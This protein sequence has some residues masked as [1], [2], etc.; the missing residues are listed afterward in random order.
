MT[1]SK[2]IT[3]GIA[4]LGR[5]G[6]DIHAKLL[7]PLPDKYKISAVFDLIP[8]RR[9]EAKD[10]F[11]CKDYTDYESLIKDPE[12]ELIINALPSHFHTSHTIQALEAGKNVVCEKPMAMNLEE[13]D[14]M[15]ECAEK[16]GNLL[17]IFQ[18]CRYATDFL[19][20][21]DIIKSGV[22][23]RIIMI[24]IAYHGFSRRW[25]W[26]TLKKYGGGTMNNTCP[27]PTDQA[28]TLMREF[29]MGKNN[30][31]VF[32]IRDKALTLG[33][34]DD[35]VKIIL[36]YPDT[37]TI[38]I[39]AT[40]TCAFSQNKWLVMGTQGGLTGSSDYLSWKYF[41]PEN[42]SERKLDTKPTWDR[43]YNSE[44]IIWINKE[45]KSEDD[46]HPGEKG[47]YLDLYNTIRNNKPVPIAPESVQQQI[48]VFDEC[49]KQA[50]I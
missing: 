15:I 29:S 2:P 17:T 45:W 40:S 31:N 41:N 24:R 42:L 21:C 1:Q 46:K 20:V 12:V 16:T 48:W 35:H 50:P 9:Q 11:K 49:R 6:W 43:S 30:P 47:F 44:E 18:N 10:K 26:Q 4:G 27:H 13:A 5:S 36:S 32:C 34:A 23:G 38:E 25:D 8:E 7:E 28:L 33:D 19:T 39:E 14:K 37:P 3:V 22:L